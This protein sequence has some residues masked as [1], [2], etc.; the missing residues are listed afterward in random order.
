[1]RMRLDLFTLIATGFMVALTGCQ[2]PTTKTSE[3]RSPFS[4]IE[5]NAKLPL[6]FGED[7]VVLDAR[8]SFD[9]GLAH[10]SEAVHFPWE[11]LAE[12]SATGQLK[13]DPSSAQR[14]LALVGISPNTSVLV[15]GSGQKGV[16]ESGRLAWTL[17]YYGI[18]DVQTVGQDAIDVYF[19][20]QETPPRKNAAPWTQA[21]N[22]KMVI[23]R[24]DFL[25]T[26]THPKVGGATKTLIL[27][28]RSKE[29]YFAK[30]GNKYAEPDIQAMNMEWKEFYGE[31]GRPN[32]AI[33]KR[34]QALGY[35]VTDEVI[36]F[37]NRGV[38]SS[39][40]AYSLIANGFKN[41]KNLITE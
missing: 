16:G 34:L 35:S 5:D 38:R 31:D 24:A 37:S 21:V 2:T 6:K 15:V 39:A 20:Q 32:L 30:K 40:A 36:V 9:Y 19:S 28:V 11:K 33:R 4:R 27:D 25:K 13:K 22:Q 29:E 8:S 12:S 23:S 7:T 3:N 17:V 14:S 18:K 1:M 26:V 10:W 41:V